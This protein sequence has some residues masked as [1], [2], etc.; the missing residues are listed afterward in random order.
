MITFLIIYFYF[1]VVRPANQEEIKEIEQGPVIP[2]S[3]DGTGK[4][5]SQYDELIDEWLI[6]NKDEDFAKIV[7]DAIQEYKET[8]EYYINVRRTS[9]QKKR[10]AYEEVVA[11]ISPDYPIFNFL[12]KRD[13]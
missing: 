1:V 11:S 3:L 7:N 9:R 4:R 10:Q 5:V 12:I 8:S 2:V 6:H 13:S